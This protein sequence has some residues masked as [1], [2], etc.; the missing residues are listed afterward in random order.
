MATH[1]TVGTCLCA[2]LVNMLDAVWDA[3]LFTLRLA[4]VAGVTCVFCWLV[5]VW[6]DLTGGSWMAGYAFLPVLLVPLL[7]AG[8]AAAKT[9][10]WFELPGGC[11]AVLA[12]CLGWRWFRRSSGKKMGVGWWVELVRLGA[13]GGVCILVL[14]APGHCGVLD[15]AERQY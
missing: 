9:L 2:T 14:Y 12:V 11:L 7:M 3:L 15:V 6:L 1:R 8:G 13:L 5:S 10:G 4:M